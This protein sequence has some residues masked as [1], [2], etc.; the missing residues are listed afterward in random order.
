MR[1]IIFLKLKTV[2]LNKCIFKGQ[3]I[4]NDCSYERFKPHKRMTTF[5]CK[6]FMTTIDRTMKNY[7][8]CTSL[9]PK[10]RHQSATNGTTKHRIWKD[11]WRFHLH[12]GL[13]NKCMICMSLI[14]FFLNCYKK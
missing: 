3:A 12:G 4:V 6:G 7:S 1:T 5:N 9:K 14:F 2:F 11:H 10:K 8:I 13:T